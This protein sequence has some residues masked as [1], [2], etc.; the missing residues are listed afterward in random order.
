MERECRRP[1]LLNRHDYSMILEIVNI[2]VSFPF[3]NIGFDSAIRFP[4]KA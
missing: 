1:P 3:L 2:Y 4:F